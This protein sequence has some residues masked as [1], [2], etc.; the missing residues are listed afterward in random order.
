MNDKLAAVQFRKKT[1][2]IEWIGTKNYKRQH[3]LHKGYCSNPRI[4]NLELKLEKQELE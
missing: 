3:D 4:R 2:G 1:A